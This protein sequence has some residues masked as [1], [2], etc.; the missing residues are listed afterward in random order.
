MLGTNCAPRGVETVSKAKPVPIYRSPVGQ[1]SKERQEA[2]NATQSTHSTTRELCLGVR[3]CAV[4]GW[5]S[6]VSRRRCGGVAV[7]VWARSA[8]GVAGTESYARSAR[9]RDLS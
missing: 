3:D 7:R 9:H 5:A 8:R 6:L 2:I 4:C 1:P